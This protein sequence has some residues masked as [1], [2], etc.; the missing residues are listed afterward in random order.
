[1]GRNMKK[2]ILAI[3]IVLFASPAFAARWC[4]WDGS[5]G[6]GCQDDLRGYITLVDGLR[7]SGSAEHFNINGYYL[8]TTTQPTV[9]E[10]SVKETEVWGKIENDISQTWT[11]REKTTE[12]INTEIGNTMSFEMYKVLSWFAAEGY[13]DPATA[14]AGIR[15]AYL[16]RQALGQ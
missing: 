9:P 5:K 10:G 14:P 8:L 6:I 7:I 11:V 12:E 16:A 2:I 15:D 4:Q 13:I 1:M 3:L